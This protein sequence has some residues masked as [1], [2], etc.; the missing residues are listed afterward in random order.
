MVFSRS[1]SLEARRH[2]D[3]QPVD[4]AER[5]SLEVEADRLKGTALDQLAL[6]GFEQMPEVPDEGEEPA[7]LGLPPS[8]LFVVARHDVDLSLASP[9]LRKPAIPPEVLETAP[10]RVDGRAGEAAKAKPPASTSVGPSVWS[11]TRHLMGRGSEPR[12]NRHRRP[13]C[14]W[15]ICTTCG[16]INAEYFVYV[17]LMQ[18]HAGNNLKLRGRDEHDRYNKRARC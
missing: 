4:V 10:T 14:R 5:D 15:C 13:G 3:Q 11:P 17:N 12:R 16:K 6:W 8:E 2:V 7:A 18:P 9:G 1:V